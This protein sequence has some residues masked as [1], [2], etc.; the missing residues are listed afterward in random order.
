MGGM[1]L[2][3]IVITLGFRRAKNQ[4]RPWAKH[5]LIFF[6]YLIAL[7][8]ILATIPWPVREVGLGRGWF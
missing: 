1:I 5:R 7:L 2:A 3:A 8:L 6:Y 4:E